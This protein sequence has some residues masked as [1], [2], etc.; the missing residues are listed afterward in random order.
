MLINFRKALNVKEIG[1]QR[2][3]SSPIDPQGSKAL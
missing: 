2:S 3:F 1:S